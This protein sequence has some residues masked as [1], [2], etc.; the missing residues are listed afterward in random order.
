MPVLKRKKPCVECPADPADIAA[1]LDDEGRAAML[2]AAKA[3]PRSRRVQLNVDASIFV[4]YALRSR[5]L[6]QAKGPYQTE[7][8]VVTELGLQV[9]AELGCST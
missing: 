2:A 8:F 3:T 6:V 1:A 5:G 7:P 4:A 9:R